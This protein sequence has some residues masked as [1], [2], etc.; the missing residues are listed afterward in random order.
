MTTGPVTPPGSATPPGG[1]PDPIR[2]K[3]YGL[4]TMTRRGYL[5]QLVIAAFLL[6]ALAVLPSFLPLAPPGRGIEVPDRLLLVLSVLKNL[7]WIALGLAVLFGI[8][9]FFVLR[10]FRRE[11]ARRQPLSSPTASGAAMHPDNQP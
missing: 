11:E 7:P 10:R 5:T 6:V 4:F 3:L 1:K 8:E 9:A 2:I